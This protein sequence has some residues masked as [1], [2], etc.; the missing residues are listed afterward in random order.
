MFQT[1]GIISAVILPLWNIPLIVRICK[2]KSSKDISLYWVT[3]VWVC[4]VLMVPSGLISDDPVWKVFNV[5]NFLLFSLVFLTV[6]I[7][8]QNNVD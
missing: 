2:R 1:V 5:V 8:R 7:C 4:Q 3:G 6:L